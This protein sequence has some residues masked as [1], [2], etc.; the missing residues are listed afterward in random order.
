[1]DFF[2]R[3]TKSLSSSIKALFNK[4]NTIR[5]EH[6]KRPDVNIP[7]AFVT[8]NTSEPKNRA[9]TEIISSLHSDLTTL[10]DKIPNV[11]NTVKTPYNK[12]TIPDVKDLLKASDFDDII[13]T[14]NA[15]DELCP[16][17]S[18]CAA[19]YSGDHANSGGCDADH[20]NFGHHT[21]HGHNSRCANYGDS[22]NSGHCGD[23][24]ASYGAN[25]PGC[26]ANYSA[27]NPSVKASG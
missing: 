14:I 16:N 12:I 4:L 23:S 3:K 8:P 19:N 7:T 5:E 6:N 13:S 18:N 15:L 1:M 25:Q 20:G 10:V 27:H 17:C 24:S 2:T 26:V 21:N 9:K 11:D 22:G